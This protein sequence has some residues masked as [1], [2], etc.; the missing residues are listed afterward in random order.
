M[1]VEKDP[2]GIVEIEGDR[3]SAHG[4]DGDVRD[5]LLR[6]AARYEALTARMTDGG[7][8]TTRST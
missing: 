4:G 8:G 7:N 1:C 5:A 2:R 3:A 6:L